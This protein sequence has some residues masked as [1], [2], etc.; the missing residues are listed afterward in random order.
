VS[1]W[2]ASAENNIH[3]INPFWHASGGSEWEA[4]QLYELL[5]RKQHVILWS[6]SIP[7]QFFLENYTIKTIKPWRLEFPKSGTFIFV[8][9]YFRIGKWIR[10]ARPHRIIIVYNTFDHADLATKTRKL[11]KLR[12]IPVEKVYVGGLHQDLLDK[13]SHQMPLSPIDIQRFFPLPDFSYNASCPFVIGRLSR[14]IDIKHH[15]DDPALYRRMANQGIA[16]KIMGG[17]VLSSELS[18]V[19]GVELLAANSNDAVAF[20]HSIDCLY[21]RTSSKWLESFGRVVLE[22]MACGL[23]VVCENRGGYCQHIRHGENGFLFD[24]D[25]EA[26]KIIMRLKEDSLLRQTIGR[27]A[28]KT[29]EE[30]Y[31]EEYISELISF[32]TGCQQSRIQQ[33]TNIFN[34]G[35]ML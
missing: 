20:L 32:Y 22:A 24:R 8:G 12:S 10:V 23:P 11:S 31:S 13:N 5:S 28:R 9:V 34:Q 14:D 1:F 2:Q 33:P 19:T 35:R 16:V 30:L 27:A 26:F 18:G 15:P 6:E 7:D 21:Y 17:T 3:I 25:E 4:L 29:V